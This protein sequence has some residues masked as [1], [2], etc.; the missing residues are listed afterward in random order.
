[1]FIKY[2]FVIEESVSDETASKLIKECLSKGS[3]AI[4]ARDGVSSL[5][6]SKMR[7]NTDIP[8]KKWHPD[9][10][11]PDLLDYCKQNH[12]LFDSEEGMFTSSIVYRY[13][14]NNFVIDPTSGD[15]I[16]DGSIPYSKIE[17]DFTVGIFKIQ[18]L[19]IMTFPKCE[20]SSKYVRYIS[21][22]S[23]NQVDTLL[24]ESALGLIN[25]I[26]EGFSGDENG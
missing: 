25:R 5:R 11:H 17:T 12:D 24:S 4:A 26:H 19:R 16:D 23:D 9:T 6:S 1:M 3:K 20:Y 18:A 2:F 15:S 14:T 13:V 10:D 21:H 22:Y 8:P 7:E